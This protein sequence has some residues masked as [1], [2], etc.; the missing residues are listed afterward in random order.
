[1][2][3][4]SKTAHKGCLQSA[5]KSPKNKECWLFI[6]AQDCSIVISVGGCESEGKRLKSQGRNPVSSFQTSFQGKHAN[7]LNLF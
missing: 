5:R 1:M 7:V 3:S 6:A 2:E 4:F